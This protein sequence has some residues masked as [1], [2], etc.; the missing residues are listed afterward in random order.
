MNNP[1]TLHVFQ[2]TTEA[3][4]VK[5][6]L[7]SEGIE[8]YYIDNHMADML[9]G[10][11]LSVLQ[12]KLVV[13][14][15]DLERANQILRDYGFVPEC[16]RINKENRFLNRLTSKPKFIQ[17]FNFESRLFIVL[18]FYLSIVVILFVLPWK[19]MFSSLPSDNILN[20][21]YYIKNIHK[22]DGEEILFPANNNLIYFDDEYVY[23]PVV[24]SR[25]DVLPYYEMNN[26]L[27]I[28]DKWNENNIFNGDFSL[29]II[30]NN[31]SMS[32][33]KIIIE[34]NWTKRM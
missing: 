30:E 12:L 34:G 10:Y 3:A 11:S 19:N 27:I 32:S 2:N 8:S 21:N 1:V 18:G 17:R 31:F 9:A 20:K 14:N 29:E 33:E 4:L 24:N 25:N 28:V 7:D 22:T 23:L 6:H 16:D 13:E 15:S 26:L 5:A